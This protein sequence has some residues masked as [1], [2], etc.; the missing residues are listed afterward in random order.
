MPGAH[1]QT[2]TLVSSCHP[3]TD[4][5]WE[6]SA[7]QNTHSAWGAFGLGG[8]LLNEAKPGCLGDEEP[9]GAMAAM[10]EI[11]PCNSSG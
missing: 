3:R 2:S 11:L 1:L 6:A 8:M 7:Q 4:L 5:P 10:V 9:G